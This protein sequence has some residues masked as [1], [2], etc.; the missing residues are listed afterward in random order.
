MTPT[1]PRARKV[2]K[3]FKTAFHNTIEALRELS[4]ALKEQTKANN[5]LLAA[6]K[7]HPIAALASD[8]RYLAAS[9]KKH[10]QRAGQ[11]HQF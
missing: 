10:L 4:A 7:E 6:F 3:K 8:V 11:P 2:I 1:K 5:A 9:E